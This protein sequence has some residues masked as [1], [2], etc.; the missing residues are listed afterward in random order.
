M[1][2]E[3]M[4]V[5][6]M[7]RKESRGVHYREDY[8]MRNDKLFDSASYILQLQHNYMKVTFENAAPNNIWYNIKKTLKIQ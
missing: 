6:A 1:I 4:V 7:Q 5:T 8:P 3:A 2:A